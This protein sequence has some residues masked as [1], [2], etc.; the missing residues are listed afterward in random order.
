MGFNSGFKVLTPVHLHYYADHEN[1][2][3]LSRVSDV[4][5]RLR[6]C[7]VGRDSVDSDNNGF[8]LFYFVWTVH[9]WIYADLHDA[10]QPASTPVLEEV[11]CV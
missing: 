9:W 10:S 8:V 3:V 4:L 7:E 1:I 11:I 2:R 5:Q 6:P